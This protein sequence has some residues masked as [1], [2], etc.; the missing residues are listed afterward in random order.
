ME[1][2]Q[3]DRTELGLL[4]RMGGEGRWVLSVFLR[5][6]LPEVPTRHARRAELNSLL[7]EAAERLRGDIAEA[8][9]V[10]ALESCLERVGH[11]L[12]DALVGEPAVHGVAYFCE[13]GGELRAYALRRQPGFDVAAAFRHGPALEPLVEA[14]PGPVW[15]VA[16]VSRKHGRVFRGSDAGLVEV[17]DIDDDVHRRHSQGGWS[18]A[19][20]QRGI[21]KE[22][23]D[24]VR[25]VCDLLFALHERRP[26]D[27]LAIVGP[28]ELLPVVESNL[29]PYL[30]QRLA[31]KLATDVEHASAQEVLE[32]VG[33]L[34]AEQRHG[35]EGEAIERLDQGLGKGER[36]VAGLAD[37]L[38]AV[39]AR[40]VETLLVS[41]GPLDEQVERAVDGAVAQAAEVLVVEGDALDGHGQI[42]ALLRY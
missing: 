28:P 2:R 33:G 9:E 18:Q 31:G 42:A 13:E 40:R 32:R 30:Q 25:R 17:G 3:I 12:E 41:H 21:E 8:A 39:E 5:L 35:Y 7:T 23:G 34:I 19:R 22:T 24:H 29:H 20:Y 4:D 26:F 11:H 14:M 6:D 10:A 15:A 36:A 27:H 1:L 38:A 37:V 16:V